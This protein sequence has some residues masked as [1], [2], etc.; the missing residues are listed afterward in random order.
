MIQSQKVNTTWGCINRG[1]RYKTWGV[2]VPLYSV[3]FRPQLHYCVQF[4]V[5]RFKK[6]VEKLEKIQRTTIIKGLEGKP[7]EERIRELSIF[8]L[9]KRSVRGT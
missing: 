9:M 3:L 2:I 7:D 1:I 5:L 8:S 4:M 6:D